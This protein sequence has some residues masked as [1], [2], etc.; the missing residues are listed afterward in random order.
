[1]QFSYSVEAGKWQPVGPELDA[2]VLSDDF[3]TGL[4]FTG[5]FIGLCAQDLDAHAA[6]AYFADFRYSPF[7]SNPH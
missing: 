5:A 7:C 2:S 1:M 4:H 6:P 3:G